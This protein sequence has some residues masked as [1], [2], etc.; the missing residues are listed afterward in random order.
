MKYSHVVQYVASTQWALLPEK[1]DDILSVLAHRA[2]GHVFTPEEIQ[3]R[4]G[5][6]RGRPTVATGTSIAVIPLR[7]TIA[8]RMGTLEDSSGG[9]SAERFTAMVNAAAADPQIGTIL[10]DVDS[11]GGTVPG[12][13]EAAD[14]VYA[15][16]M[17]GTRVVAVA[18]S[19]MASAAYWICSG[20]DEIVGIPSALEGKIGSIGTYFV[21][22]DLSAA[23]EQEGIKVTFISAGKYKVDGGP[24]APLSDERRAELQK[25]ADETYAQFTQA[26]ARGRGVS[27]SA[28]RA[29]YGEGR[30]LTAKD[31]LSAGL[32]N[33]ISTMDD[34]I[35]ELCGGSIGQGRAA[36]EST[37]ELVAMIEDDHERRLRLL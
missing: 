7:G 4:L 15:A 28:V 22:K 31:A 32:I 10:L 20:A 9:M 37:P 29:G 19:M 12:V 5:D 21:H 34:V 13:P 6:Q 26:V 17:G 3:S 23:L 2:A 35:E 30:A 25:M 11:P 27:V 36:V 18:N 24:F 8:H 33:R 16:R 14:A 1:M